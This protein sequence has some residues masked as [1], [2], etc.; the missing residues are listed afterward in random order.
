MRRL[1]QKKAVGNK[2]GLRPKKNKAVVPKVSELEQLNLNA[3]AIDIGSSSHFVAVPEGRD[4]TSVREFQ[5]FTSD[6]YRLADWLTQ[7][8][9]DTVAMEATGIYWI[10]VFEVLDARG[11]KVLL[12]DARQTKNV[13]G[14]KSDVLDCQWIRQLHTY[15]L[16]SGAFRPA[17]EVCV[18]RSYVR[19]RA[20]LIESAAS[21]IQHMQKA[22]HQMNLLLH[23]VVNDITGVTGMGIIRAILKGERDPAVLASLRHHRC[24][25]SE[26]V[27][28]QSLV[29]NYREEHLF[30]LQQAVDLYD[31]YQTKIS[32]CDQRIEEYLKVLD[33]VRDDKPGGGGKQNGRRSGGE[34]EAQ[35]DTRTPLYQMSGVDL[36]R[37]DGIAAQTAL[38]LISEIGTDMTRWASEK[39]FT[40]WL[41][42]C[43]GTKTSGGKVLSSKSRPCANRAAMALRMAASTLY[44][45]QSALGAYLRRMTARLGKA[46][47]ITATAH[48]MARLV[49]QML[50]HGT[51]YVDIGQEAYETVYRD[52]V[53]KNLKRKAHALGYELIA[54]AGLQKA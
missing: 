50:K 45:S 54:P 11:F 42:V 36:T 28:A 23:N 9:I 18:L 14:R 12:V 22:L 52:R 29:G 49:Y 48:K 33:K 51:D 30:S 25:N 26:E 27:I 35:V 21:H 24:R 1:R 47:A 44:R 17:D 38:T 32:E 19:Q 13:S 3:A 43:P 2:N 4:P 37:I 6:L 53:L 5:S 7:C 39:R 46:A 10:P 16:L 41:G 31:L 34:K 20:M 15:G 8:G 40:S